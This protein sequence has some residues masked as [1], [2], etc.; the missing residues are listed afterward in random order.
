MVVARPKVSGAA[1]VLH[2]QALAAKFPGLAQQQVQARVAALEAALE[3]DRYDVVAWDARLTEAIREGKSVPIFERAVALFPNA[4]RLWTFYAETIENQD[5]EQAAGIYQRCLQQLP[6]LELW[7][8]YITSCKRYQSLEDI[9]R[10]YQRAVELLGTDWRAGPLW[11]EYIALMKKAYNLQQKKINPDAEVC[12]RLLN[13]DANPVEAARRAMK[14][15]PLLR[16]RAEEL[17]AFDVGDE[18][19]LRVSEVLKIDATALRSAF[20]QAISSA[21]ASL[22]KLWVGYKQFEKSL[23]NPQLAQK[24][25]L[26]FTPRYTRGKD[27]YKELTTLCV[28]MDM[29]AIAVP[30]KP[31]NAVAQRR[32]LERWRQVLEYERTN[33]LRLTKPELHSRAILVYQQASMCLSYHAEIWHDFASWL[34]LCDRPEAAATCLRDAVSRFL[35]QDLTLRLLIASRLELSEVPPS[36][37]SLQAADHAYQKLLEDMPAPCPLA[38]INYLSFLRRQRGVHDFRDAFLEAT[39]TSPHCSW[40]VY[41]FAALTEYHVY[42]SV[43]AADRTF[44]LG[45]E[46]FGAQEPSLLAAFVNFLVGANDLQGARALLSKG[47]LERMQAGVKDRSDPQVRNSLAF[48]WQKWARLERYF[49]DPGAVRRATAFR[50]EEY[51]NMQR[52]HEVEEDAVAETPVTLGLSTT[53]EEVEESFRFQHLLPQTASAARAM[54]LMA[55]A[56]AAAAGVQPHA[57]AQASLPAASSGAG[58]P[59]AVPPGP[60][61][62]LAGGAAASAATPAAA[63][64]AAASEAST[65][66]GQPP[67]RDQAVA[68]ATEEQ[69]RLAGGRALAGAAA[70]RPLDVAGQRPAAAAGGVGVKRPGEDGR[71]KLPTIIPKCIQDL[72]AVLPS[73]PLKGA[74]PDVD[75]LLTVLQTVTIPPIQLKDIENIRYDS[76]RLSKEEETTV[77]KRRLGKEED[78]DGTNFFSLRP[79]L[80]RDRMRAKRQKVLDEKRETKLEPLDDKRATKL[81]LSH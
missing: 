76:V 34:D 52:E 13:E 39:N 66:Q 51:R 78:G 6:S 46:R 59:A 54:E 56:A 9:F 25:V 23:G 68:D 19:F 18:E 43:D 7:S 37:A 31:K 28:G 73:R 38:L 70:V 60:L 63:S 45:L 27:V 55:P 1:V 44:R 62:A 5:L 14:T 72:L 80:Y 75:Y 64:T 65:Q 33:P 20:Q 11:S 26:E 81:E 29:N 67:L 24:L 30:V 40:E 10:A 48:L 77:W 47:V 2:N 41:A 22:D 50:D 49:G 15:N 32:M 79:S 71:P 42:G 16:K 35:P 17:K 36:Q 3:A 21:H 58:P 61:P 4:P 12:G 57:A 74:K 53:I 8:S 69:R